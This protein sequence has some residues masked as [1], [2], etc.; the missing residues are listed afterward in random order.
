LSVWE[1]R[2]HKL[3]DRSRYKIERVFGYIQRWFGRL[4]ARY[5]GMAKTHGQHVLGA[6]AYNLYRLSAGIMSKA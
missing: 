1:K 2:Y 5:V 4:A 3:M 6:I